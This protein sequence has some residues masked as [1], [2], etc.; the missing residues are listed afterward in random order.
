MAEGIAYS[1]VGKLAEYT[2]D[3]ILRQ[4]KNSEIIGEEVSSWLL[5]VDD[6]KEKSDEVLDSVAASEMWCLFNRCPNLKTRYLLSRRATKKTIEAD[7]LKVEGTFERVSCPGPSVQVLNLTSHEDLETRL[8]TKKNIKDALKDKDTSIIGIC[9]MPGVGKT[10]MAKEIVNELKD[11]K[12]FEEV[13]F[14]VVSSDL[15]INK[16]QDQLAEMLGLKIEEKTN[17]DAR[18]ERLHE[19]IKGNDG[20]SI[21]VVLDDVWGEIDLGTIGIPSP[22]GQE[23]LKIMF[24]MR[25]EEDESIPIEN[26]VRYAR[27]LELFKKTE[28]LYETRDRAY[29]IVDNLK[30]CNL[31][32]PD[33]KED[34]VKLHDVIRDFCL[35]MAS[36]DKRGYLA[37]HAGLI[38]WP[39]HDADDSYSAI[40]ITF[41]KLDQLQSGLK[42]PNVKLL[43][44]ICCK[45]GECKISEEFFK[46][47]KELFLN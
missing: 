17:K 35:Q 39:E 8:S 41:D 25:N 31:L 16:I 37:T 9:G 4:I 2:V 38:G 6:L 43:R 11:E 13:A 36:E 47:M 46:D 24:T 32:Q 22:S 40:S 34:E 21:L 19:R 33:E 26:L 10:T 18:A 28:K 14:A 27:G 15:D 5:K 20:K 44:M 1:I 12:V 3:P 29:S 23:G 7:K 42:Y 30:S 45:E